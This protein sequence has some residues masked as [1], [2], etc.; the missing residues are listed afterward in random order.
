MMRRIFRSPRSGR[1]AAVMKVH[2]A[3][4][5]NLSG[6][7]GLAMVE[8]QGGRW[9]AAATTSLRVRRAAVQYK[10]RVARAV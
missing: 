7:M 3:G 5:A 2:R 8:G 1:H 10:Q 9:A 4:H 6:E